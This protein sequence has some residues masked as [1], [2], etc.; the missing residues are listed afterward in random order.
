MPCRSTMMAKLESKLLVE[1]EKLLDNLKKARYVAV[2][3]D[4][5][6]SDRTQK[7]YTTYTC[8]YFDE[9]TGA[10]C[11]KVLQTTPFGNVAHTGINIKEDL[12]EAFKNWQIQGIFIN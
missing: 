12:E 1:Q 2:T 5:W 8:T 11:F 10:L 3:T 6:T 9:I 7:Y 4:G